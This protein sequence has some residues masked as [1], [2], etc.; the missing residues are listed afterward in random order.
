MKGFGVVF[1]ALVALSSS[2]PAHGF[3]PLQGHFMAVQPCFASRSIQGQNENPI[4]LVEG[5]VYPVFGLNKPDGAF[6]QI[7][8][9][10]L[11]PEGRW[12][13]RACGS[14][15]LPETGGP[16]EQNR[17][18]RARSTLL[19]LSWQPAFCEKHTGKQ[20][21]RKQ[22]D[23]LSKEV[24]G[25]SLHGLWPEPQAL[26]YCDVS[27]LQRRADEAK[28]WEALPEPLL[29]VMTRTRLAQAMPGVLSNLHRH[30][31]IRHGRCFGLDAERYFTIALNL[32]EQFNHWFMKTDMA[33]RL[34]KMLSANELRA[35]F[36]QHY[37]VGTGPSLGIYCGQGDSRRLIGEL[38]IR[39]K[40]PLDETTRLQDA[41]NPT[42][43][44][45]GDCDGGTVDRAGMD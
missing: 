29:D 7:R 41:L 43:P 11:M 28:Q 27:D 45:G 38:R 1:G 32:Q 6:V 39:L 10:G 20:E 15:S 31:W 9:A 2:L 21:C 13:S 34:G 14:L 42:L 23:T 3:E 12:V 22:A 44:V 8:V 25:F 17:L 19:A 37:G 33:N 5:V 35:A 4:R 36:E 40:F 18:P 30:E 26:Q 16:S 24:T